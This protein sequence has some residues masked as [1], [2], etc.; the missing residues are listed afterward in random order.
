M[1]KILP[2]SLMIGGGMCRLCWTPAA[3][4]AFMNEPQNKHGI[5]LAQLNFIAQGPMV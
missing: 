4:G 5:F 1:D 2:T 3:R